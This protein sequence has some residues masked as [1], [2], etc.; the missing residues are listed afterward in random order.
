MS[1]TSYFAVWSLRSGR[2][3]PHPKYSSISLSTSP[4]SAFWLTEK[5][6]LTSHPPRILV[7]REK[8]TVKHPSPST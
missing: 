1:R 2:I 4:R 5:L 8:D 3:V 6:G 7:R